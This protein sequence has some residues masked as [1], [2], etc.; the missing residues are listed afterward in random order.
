MLAA[1]KK[2]LFAHA[3]AC[4]SLCVYV[5]VLEGAGWGWRVRGGVGGWGLCRLSFA[6][7]TACICVC[8]DW[9]EKCSYRSRHIF[10]R[11]FTT[12][13]C[14]SVPVRQRAQGERQ[15]S[16]FNANDTASGWRAFSSR[17]C[18]RMVSSHFHLFLFHLAALPG[19]Y[20]QLDLPFLLP[21][22]PLVS[23]DRGPSW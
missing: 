15:K 9:S 7:L 23:P 12:C 14:P 4:M 5:C 6:C 11:P 16:F 17:S 20:K 8:T 18:P 1:I 13:R 2:T 21:P 10:P 22:P 3:C 19:Q